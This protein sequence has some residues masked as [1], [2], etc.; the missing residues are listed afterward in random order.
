M[1]EKFIPYCTCTYCNNLVYAINGK[2]AKT[3]ILKENYLLKGMKNI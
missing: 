2:L 3:P 1:E